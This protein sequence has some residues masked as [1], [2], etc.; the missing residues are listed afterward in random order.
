MKRRKKKADANARAKRKKQFVP[1]TA[2]IRPQKAEALQGI[3]D[4]EHDGN[5]SRV[6]RI[7]IDEFLERKVS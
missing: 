4:T 2:T 3:A 6:V 7:A 5:F 1:V